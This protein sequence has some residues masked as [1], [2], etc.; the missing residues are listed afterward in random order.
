MN[1]GATAQQ[2]AALI[3]YPK[4]A[5]FGRVLPKNKIYEHSGANTRLKDLFVEQVEQIVWQYKLAPETINLPAR[6]GVPEIQIFNVQLKSSEL[7]EDVLR[8]IDGAVQFPILFELN[9]GQGDQAQTQVVA[10]YKRPS[11]ADASRW[12]LS[13]YFATD[14]M[15]VATARTAMPLALDMAYLYAALL[16]ELLPMPPRSQ[17]A[18]PDWIARV[19]LAASKRR[20]VEK[21][22]T[23]LAKEKQF[24]RKVEIN[25]ALRQLKSELEQLS[26]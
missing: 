20:E 4:Q 5:A 7:H 23:R 19:E 12:V 9:Q 8:C 18:L 17:E 21:T 11:E 13:S 24:N 10:A 16:R 15:P 2:R 14:W 1:K 6:P 22:Q 25:A 3:A 26:R